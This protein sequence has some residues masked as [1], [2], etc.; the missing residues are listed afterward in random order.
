MRRDKV[1]LGRRDWA[2]LAVVPLI[3]LAFL[4]RLCLAG[5]ILYGPDAF[6]YFYP[7]YEYASERVLSGELPLWN[8]HLFLGAPFLANPQA[9]VLYPVHWVLAGLPAPSLASA[10]LDLH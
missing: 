3:V 10:S 1:R 5:Q 6:A 4:W 2:L 7:L 8:P 9:G